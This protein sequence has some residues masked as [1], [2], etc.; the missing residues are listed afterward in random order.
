MTKLLQAAWL[1]SLLIGA[2][3]SALAAA[4]LQ[5]D[6]GILK[7]ATG[8]NIGGT[9]YNVE[10]VDT[11]CAAAFSGCDQSSDFLFQSQAEATAAA[12]ALLGQVLIDGP[13]GN[14]DSSPALTLGCNV[15]IYCWVVNAFWDAGVQ[16]IDAVNGDDAS[17]A[18]GVYGPYLDLDAGARDDLTFA[19]WTLADTGRVPEPGSLL[20]AGVALAALGARRRAR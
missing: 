5:V 19:R 18:D 6:G 11:T 17:I 4:V 10:F 3:T 12:N 9:L 15:A 20:L 7:G 2:S 16:N 8:V 13:A 1:T 14:F